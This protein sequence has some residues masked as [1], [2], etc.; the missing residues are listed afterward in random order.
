M[1]DFVPN[2]HGEWVNLRYV[3]LVR[4][5]SDE[6]GEGRGLLMMLDGRKHTVSSETCSLLKQVLGKRWGHT[7]D[8]VS[9]PAMVP[10]PVPP[11]DRD[12]KPPPPGPPEGPVKKPSPFPTGP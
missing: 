2:I 7:M 8:Q 6:A 12:D 1:D 4:D 10:I 11:P 5:F 3:V 9:L